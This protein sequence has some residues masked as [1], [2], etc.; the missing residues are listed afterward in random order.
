MLGCSFLCCCRCFCFFFLLLFA[1]ILSMLRSYKHP[2]SAT[3]GNTRNIVALYPNNI[4]SVCFHSLVYNH[5][6]DDKIIS[7][8]CFTLFQYFF[9]YLSLSFSIFLC[10]S[11]ALLLL[12]VC[13]SFASRSKHKVDGSNRSSS[14]KCV[15]NETM[16]DSETLWGSTNAQKIREGTSRQCWSTASRNVF[17]LFKDNPNEKYC[18]AVVFF[19]FVST[20][21]LHNFFMLLLLLL[22]L[23]MW[24]EASRVCVREWLD[25]TWSR[26]G[27]DGQ[28]D[29][30]NIWQMI[31]HNTPLPMAPTS[32]ARKI[33]RMIMTTMYVSVSVS[34]SVCVYVVCMCCVVVFF[35]LFLLN[36][37][38]RY[39][40]RVVLFWF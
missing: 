19:S 40:Q 28:S 26:D 37:F 25:L 10:S 33:C 20:K 27:H 4:L 14:E 11:I 39:F 3:I 29:R 2:G 5:N 30:G 24:F 32:A 9:F 22:I 23:C 18:N 38:T 34:V 7:V 1:F 15:L 12:W 13:Y 17:H 35:S 31:Q 36:N 21:K 16:C 6:D 8:C